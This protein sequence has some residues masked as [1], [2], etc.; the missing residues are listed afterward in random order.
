METRT[1]EK[2]KR[3][4]ILYWCLN[5]GKKLNSFNKRCKNCG[6][7]NNEKIKLGSIKREN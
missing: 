1:I 2:I 7:R 3:K 4:P 5:C 6:H